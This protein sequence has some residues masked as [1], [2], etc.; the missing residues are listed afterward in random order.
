MSQHKGWYL[1]Q[2]HLRRIFG[3]SANLRTTWLL[4]SRKGLRR[5]FQRSSITQKNHISAAI[6]QNCNHALDSLNHVVRRDWHVWGGA[7][8]A[9]NLRWFCIV[10]P[11]DPTETGY[12]PSYLLLFARATKCLGG[13]ANARGHDKI[14]QS[15]LG[16]RRCQCN[17]QS[18][19]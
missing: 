11:P 7:E 8:R 12:Q 10:S 16:R 19:P 17:H 5:V 1:E 2:L 15:S 14:G 18:R 9:C 4:T 6:S 13:L 3:H